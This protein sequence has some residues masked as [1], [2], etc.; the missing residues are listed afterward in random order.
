[1]QASE[2]CSRGRYSC[3]I[4]AAIAVALTASAIALTWETFRLRSAWPPA[5][6]PYSLDVPF[7]TPL[8]N[9]AHKEWRLTA[10]ILTFWSVVYAVALLRTIAL[11]L[12][13]RVAVV[14]IALQCVLL[15]IVLANR[16]PFNSDQY[17]YVA[18]GDLV[19][20]G[21]NPYA[22]PLKTLPD[23]PPAIAPVSTVWSINQGA[24]DAPQRVV[25]RD[26]YGPFFT[27]AAG[28]V[29]FPFH[30]ASAETQ[31]LVLRVTAA[32]ACAACSLLLAL[33]SLRRR[34]TALPLAAFALSPAIIAQ[35]AQGAHNDIYALF[36]AL[37][38][39]Y[40]LTLNRS[41]LA[42]LALSASI[43]VKLSFAPFALP[44]IAYVIAR[45][46]PRNG[47][48]VIAAIA[49]PL[50]LFAVPFGLHHAL[51]Q[52]VTD[53]QK[54]NGP[55]IVSTVHDAM[56]HL[57]R[58]LRLDERLLQL[59]YDAA[60]I[61][62]TLA[63]T[64]RAARRHSVWA[65]GAAMLFLTYFAGNLE[66]WYVMILVPLLLVPEAW[67]APL[68]IG[69]SLASQIFQGNDF[70]ERFRHIPIVPFMILTVLLCAIAWGVFAVRPRW[71]TRISPQR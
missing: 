12:T 9:D 42:G 67:A 2:G 35:T 31:A 64:Y 32:I 20:A 15:T 58:S 69:T 70:V 49:A 56:R 51:L 1:M 26:R 53:L 25:V 14:I 4:V 39:A 29:L 43:G 36:F 34:A 63:A 48:I 60:L 27:L 13:R 65:A 7:V 30:D 17:V 55:R 68:F 38:A 19:D 46:G 62:C 22:P 6:W 50:V 59:A 33:W 3:G 41:L 16:I 23:L 8:I 44:L 54:F 10:A 28:A 24:A 52:P 57:P 18:Y 66:P 37:A 21:Q 5:A 45:R 11:P 47:I 71:R 40:A 61:G